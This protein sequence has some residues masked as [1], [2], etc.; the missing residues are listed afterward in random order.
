MKRSLRPIAKHQ[1]GVK[2]CSDD[3]KIEMWIAVAS[4]WRAGFG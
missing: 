3:N 2:H 1:E 4:L